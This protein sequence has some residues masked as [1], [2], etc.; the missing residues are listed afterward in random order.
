MA[1]I[2]FEVFVC[3][4][5]KSL[6][7]DSFVAMLVFSK[8]L[9]KR[10]GVCDK[11]IDDEE[12]VSIQAPVCWSDWNEKTQR[13][14]WFLSTF[15]TF[16]CVFEIRK[17][18]NAFSK[19]HFWVITFSSCVSFWLVLTSH[20]IYHLNITSNSSHDL[21]PQHHFERIICFQFCTNCFA[22]STDGYFF[23]CSE[24]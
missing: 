24:E 4:W 6:P 1:Q 13:R 10:C 12:F 23:T 22:F 15:K 18:V 3:L 20:Q 5:N 8:F 9:R 16:E 7:D 21:S 2:S 11:M 14:G 17:L 19:F